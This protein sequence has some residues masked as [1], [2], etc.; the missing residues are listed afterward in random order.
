[1]INDLAFSL[2]TVLGTIKKIFI[3]VGDGVS[4]LKV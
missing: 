2:S 1:M 4:P 3:S